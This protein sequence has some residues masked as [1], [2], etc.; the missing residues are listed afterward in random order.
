M[1][2]QANDTLSQLSLSFQ[3]A[4]FFGCLADVALRM[5]GFIARSAD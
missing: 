3:S 5:H 2:L 4:V 1:I